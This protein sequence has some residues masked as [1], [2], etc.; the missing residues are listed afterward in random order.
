MKIR[1]FL[2]L[3]LL[4]VLLLV[5]CAPADSPIL[6]EPEA[7]PQ[8]AESVDEEPPTPTPAEVEPTAVPT[9]VSPTEAAASESEPEFVPRGPDLEA[10]DPATVSL[11]S[12]GLQLVEFFRFT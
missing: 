6:A 4:T 1:S 11:E 2:A 5:S 3:G 7:P 12:G 10:T 9:E 8:P